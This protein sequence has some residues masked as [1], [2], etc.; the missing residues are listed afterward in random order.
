M[1]QVMDVAVNKGFKSKVRDALLKWCARE[2]QEQRFNT[3][4]KRSD[5]IEWV[6]NA[7]ETFPS[8]TIQASMEKLILA[9]ALAQEEV[10]DLPT[11][12]VEPV[13]Q[14]DQDEEQRA[15]GWHK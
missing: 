14:E 9:H 2:I 15:Q 13:E 8:N 1:L 3:K 12:V 10:L 7:W 6:L 4:P 11:S 5:V